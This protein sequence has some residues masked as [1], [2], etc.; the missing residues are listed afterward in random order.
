MIMDIL[1]HNI[2]V[3]VTSDHIRHGI[4]QDCEKCPIALAVSETLRLIYQVA[5][6]EDSI[7]VLDKR[8]NE[9]YRWDM[10][11]NV[12]DFISGFDNGFFCSP[13]SFTILKNDW[14]L[15]KI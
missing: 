13:I 1:K 11:Q 9:S 15:Q 5:I 14:V 8:T 6:G 4:Q 10:P 7:I 2:K 3:N 12:Q